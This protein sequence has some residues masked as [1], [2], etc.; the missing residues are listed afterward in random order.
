[1]SRSLRQFLYAEPSIEAEK[2]LTATEVCQPVMASL[3]LALDALL[4]RMG[5]KADFTLGH[6]LGEFAAAAAAGVLS[7]EDCV[8]LVQ[9]RGEAMVALRLSDPGAMASAASASSSPT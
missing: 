7:P 2:R 4:K 8:R 6:S 1:P 9:R 5:V 3:G